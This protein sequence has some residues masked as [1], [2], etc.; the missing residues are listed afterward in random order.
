MF[1]PKAS[2]PSVLPQIIGMKSENT[3]I[4]PFKSLSAPRIPER[5][6]TITSPP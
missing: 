5:S 6:T 1:I 3:G 4:V 2:A